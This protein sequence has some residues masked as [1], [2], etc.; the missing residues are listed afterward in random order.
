MKNLNAPVKNISARNM[1]KISEENTEHVFTFNENG[2]FKDSKLADIFGSKL[3]EQGK[4]NTNTAFEIREGK[5]FYRTFDRVVPMLIK[6]NIVS[7]NP[8]NKEISREV[9][10]TYTVMAKEKA[11]GTELERARTWVSKKR[12][13]LIKANNTLL[14]RENRK[15]LKQELE[16]K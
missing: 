12:E 4:L 14:I 8:E 9:G 1:L 16:Q 5:G 2:E 11:A 7:L 13:S 15:K 3:I 6:V 10:F